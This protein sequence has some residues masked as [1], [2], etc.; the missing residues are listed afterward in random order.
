MSCLNMTHDIYVCKRGVGRGAGWEEEGWQAKLNLFCVEQWACPVLPGKRG[1]VAPVWG[2]GQC[3]D[4][5]PPRA[6]VAPAH[7]P[8]PPAW[9]LAAAARK[10]AAQNMSQKGR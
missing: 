5:C 10:R 1:R 9:P 3:V 7:R 6:R 8:P 2:C 4:A